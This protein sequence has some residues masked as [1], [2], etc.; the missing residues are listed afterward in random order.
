MSKDKKDALM[1]AAAGVGALFATRALLRRVRDY[2]LRGKSVLITGGSRGLGLVMAREFI[3][4]G[5]RVCICARDPAELE[6]A[7]YLVS[8]NVGR[9]IQSLRQAV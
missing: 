3:N 7:D 2:D 4:E 5:A 1:L 8:P 6:R 9:T